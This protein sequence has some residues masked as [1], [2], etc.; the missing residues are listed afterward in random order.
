MSK[1]ENKL[2]EI[3]FALSSDDIIRILK[4]VTYNHQIM[5]IDG[6]RVK[7]SVYSRDRSMYISRENWCHLVAA[8]SAYP[9]LMPIINLIAMGDARNEQ[10]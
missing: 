1:I 7:V 8:A 9:D 5:T 6:Q 3:N 2:I 10:N 4:G